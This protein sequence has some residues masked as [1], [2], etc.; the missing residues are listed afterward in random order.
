[1]ATAGGATELVSRARAAS[2][3]GAHAEAERLLGEALSLQPGSLEAL[4]LRAD[5][6]RCQGRHDEALEDLSELARLD[7]S[8]SRLTA[9]GEGKRHRRDYAGAL[10]D[11]ELV[12]KKA[13]GDEGALVLA[14]EALRGLGRWKAAA[15]AAKKAAAVS[16]SSWPDVVRAKALRFSG[17]VKGAL[18]ALDDA[19]ERSPGDHYVLGWRGEVLRKAKKPKEA[20][21][22]LTAALKA[23]PRIAWMRAVLGEALRESGRAQEGLKELLE[24]VRLDGNL[25]CEYDFLGAE[26]PAVK[27][28]ASLA[29]LYAWRGAHRF[30]RGDAAGKADLERAAKLDPKCA[31]IRAWRGET[32]L[33]EDRHADA[34]KELARASKDA[35]WY[36]D[37][38][39]WHGQSL[40]G[41]GRAKD[42]LSRFDAAAKADPRSALAR[43]GRAVA[44]D[45]LGRR[46]EAGKELEAAYA[47][48]P[49]L[50][51]RA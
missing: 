36:A 49:S 40:L 28:D 9:R 51:G 3:D 39:L 30:R 5:A 14:S 32:L 50:R 11:A 18:A 46:G 22:A 20:V 38:A 43:V 15:D 23:Q 35:P 21:A 25:S 41:L 16:K 2:R 33:R 48:D 1:M 29:W 24:A 4:S 47:L 6:R 31:W 7:P 10:A 27:S 45:A 34:A 12:L 42:A 13:P 37:A 44:L 8:P 19:E 17:D 26:P